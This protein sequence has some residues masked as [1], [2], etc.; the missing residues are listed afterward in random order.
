MN[1]KAFDLCVKSAGLN[2][3]TMDVWGEHNWHSNLMAVLS[4]GLP[5]LMCREQLLAVICAKLPNYSKTDDCRK[6]ID[7]FFEKYSA[8]KGFM[9]VS[10]RNINAEAQQASLA[11]T[12]GGESEDD[13]DMAALTQGWDAPQLPKKIP[14]LMDLLVNNYDPRFREMLLLTALPV[15]SAHASHFR[16]VY[17]NGKTIGPQ[18]Y[19]AVIGG[20][21][22]G[23]GNCTDLYKEMVQYTLKDNDDREWQKVE[24]NTALRDKMANQKERP[25]KYHPK[26]RLFETTSKSSILELQKN[27]GKNGML[28][29]QFSEVDG[30]SGA[31]RAAY[32][33]ISVL[34]RK[35]WD[36]D[37]H[38][39]FY[40][41]DATC[42]T[43]AQM[44]ISLLMA[45]TVRAMLERM[46]NDSNCE[47][48]LMQRCIPVIVP[49]SQRT[50]RP[51]MQNF[52]SGDE[53]KER[54]AL[55]IELYQRDLSLGD[56][57]LTLETPLTNHA[58]GEWF[59]ELEVR[60]NM[61]QLTEAEADLS[62]RCG[63]FMLRAAIPLIALYGK[64]TKEIVDFSRWVG[65]MAHYAMCRL[66][67]Y[68]VQNDNTKSDELLSEHLEARKPVNPLLDQLPTIF[69]TQQMKDL[70]IKLGLSPE[71]KMLLSRL[72]KSGKIV[73]LGRGVW[74][75]TEAVAN[76]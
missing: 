9:S 66:F 72:V 11:A 63:E 31:S 12:R 40:M 22:K 41:S 74:Q 64:E 33:D 18:Q 3:E 46:F 51:P 6:L 34:L 37:M 4:V 17:L 68:R 62:H 61:G 10:L 8:D 50:F 30:L 69:S 26:L 57:T 20:S 70:R 75:K 13:K 28:L 48:G 5:K 35:G 53:K 7:Y 16:A 36:M 58:I 14:R 55:L 54:D 60:Y 44:S 59:D 23:K 73:K 38:R 24:E 42:N 52:L 65:E 39:Q 19:V 67:G 29:G 1:L 45:G 27:L 15:L 32:S 25:P 76:N 2:P 47:G 49:K 56:D 71:V 21:G 43:Y